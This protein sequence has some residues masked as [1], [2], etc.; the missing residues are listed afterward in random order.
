MGIDPLTHK[1]LSI[2]EQ[3]DEE[4]LKQVQNNQMPLQEPIKKPLVEPTSYCLTKDSNIKNMNDDDQFMAINLEYGVEEVPLIDPE[5]LGIFCSNS[6]MSSSTSTSS[7]SSNDSSF[8]KDLQFPDF[9]WS[10][11]YGNNNGVDNIIE[12]NMMSL[13]DT[14]DFSSWDLLLNDESSST[15]GLF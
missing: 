12:N 10:N 1:P 11:N 5:C 6:E 13:W 9:D 4:P 3:E 2:V 15:F 14:N 8:L 7:N